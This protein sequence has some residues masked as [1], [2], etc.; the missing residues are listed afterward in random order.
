MTKLSSIF[1]FVLLSLLLLQSFSTYGQGNSMSYLKQ[2]F[3]KLTNL[4]QEELLNSNTHYIFA[5]DVSGSMIQYNDVVTPAIQAFVRAL[6]I[7][8]QVSI[9]PFGTT[10]HENT[11]GLCCKID[12]NTKRQ[13]EISLSGLYTNDGYTREFRRNTDVGKAM[14]AINKA[15]LN[16][17]NA[18]INVIVIIT[19]FLNDLPNGGE[20]KLSDDYLSKLNVD[21]D[22]VTNKSYTRVVALQLPKAGTGVG[23]CLDQLQ[24][25]VFCNLSE[26]KRFDRVPAIKDKNAIAHWFE[27]LSRDIMTEKLK[28]VIELDNKQNRPLF[29]AT[30]DIDGNTTAEIHW[31]PNKL[32]QSLQIDSIATESQSLYTFHYNEEVLKAYQDTALIDMELGQLKH[33]N[34]GLRKFD[35][36]LNIGLSLPTPYDDELQTLSISKPLQ[37]SSDSKNSW[38]FTFFLPFKVTVALLILLII[39]IILVIK[40][41]IRNANERF[42]GKVE[43]TDKRGRDIGDTIDV[44]CNPSQTLYIGAGGNMGCGLSGA[45]WTIQIKKKKAF[46]L[47]FWERPSFEWSVKPGNGFVRDGKNKQR[48]LLGRYGK[49]NTRSRID[50]S[51]GPDGS[52]ITHGVKISI[53]KNK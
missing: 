23:F 27:Q 40:S 35:E 15:M 5:V 6:P 10:T 12:D 8:E 21:F 51:C 18:Q 25:K 13:V 49:K 28:A 1:K 53:K 22:N 52:N 11:I 29:K 24:E 33:K 31:T 7:G 45:T 47:A 32:Y 4:Y 44:R 14:E 48:G 38:V 36:N 20:Q 34:W 3:P 30:M 26:T 19:D 41:I 17:Q 50:L 43:F 2:V 37:S 46:P 16:N 9:M 39:Y 42:I